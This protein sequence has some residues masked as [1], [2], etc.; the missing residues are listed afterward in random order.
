VVIIAKETDT[1]FI[2]VECAHGLQAQVK[3][4]ASQPLGC[5][6]FITSIGGVM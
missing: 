6:S 4:G 5:R 3:L 1:N 2:L